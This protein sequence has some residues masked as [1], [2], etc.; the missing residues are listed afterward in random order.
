MKL[1]TVVIESDVSLFVHGRELGNIQQPLKPM[2]WTKSKSPIT[3]KSNNYVSFAVT[4]FKELKISKMSQIPKLRPIQTTDS[5]SHRPTSLSQAFDK[6]KTGGARLLA[7]IAQAQQMPAIKGRHLLL[8]TCNMASI[9]RPDRDSD[10]RKTADRLT[11]DLTERVGKVFAKKCYPV[12]TY[13]KTYVQSIESYVDIYDDTSTDTKKYK[14]MRKKLGNI[15]IRRLARELCLGEKEKVQAKE[16][17]KDLFSVDQSKDSINTSIPAK[18]KI[19]FGINDTEFGLRQITIENRAISYHQLDVGEK[20]LPLQFKATNKLRSIVKTRDN[21]KGRSLI[22]ISKPAEK[23]DQSREMTRR[24]I[25]NPLVRKID[26]ISR[27]RKQV[28]QSNTQ[29]EVNIIDCWKRDKD[30]ISYEDIYD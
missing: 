24:K 26:I 1:K 23:L 20:L 16:Q 22:T 30:Y 3:N 15:L 27:C 21:S 28:I 6:T 11:V 5:L 8:A 12:D 29:S 7:S 13:V 17:V 14:D 4:P 18:K 25:R 19:S 10:C 2:A 9:K